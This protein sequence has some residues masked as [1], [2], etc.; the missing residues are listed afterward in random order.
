MDCRT[1]SWPNIVPPEVS[2]MLEALQFAFMRRALTAGLLVS[3]ACGV[4]GVLVIVNRIVFI[5]GGIAHAAYGGVGLGY[6]L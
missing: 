2:S 6:Y 4:I 1:A 3:V 5:S